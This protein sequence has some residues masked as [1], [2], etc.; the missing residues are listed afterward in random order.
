MHTTARLFMPGA[1]GLVLGA[2]ASGSCTQFP[3]EDA[4]LNVSFDSTRELYQEFNG[5][6][7]A[8]WRVRT[9]QTVTVYQS[10]GGSAKQARAVIEGLAADVVTLALDFDVDQIASKSG[11]LSSGWRSRLPDGAAPY[12]ST[13]VFLVRKG[14]PHGISDWDDLGR[15]GIAVVTPHPKVSGGGRWN[16]LGAWAWALKAYRGDESRA[17]NF[18]AALYRNVPLLEPSSRAAGITFARRGIGDVLVAWESEARFLRQKLGSEFEIVTPSVS[19]RA[20]LPVAVVDRNVERHKT[21]KLAEAYVNFF[22]TPAGQRLLARHH[23]RPRQTEARDA[24][25][26]PFPVLEQVEGE[27]LGGWTAIQKAHFADGGLFDQVYGSP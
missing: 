22:W 2:L 19:V 4:L 24:A 18:M 3:G 13:V 27:A 16:Y 17:R 20:A 7:A 1:I 15:E 21:R 5:A 23:F 25:S 14:N 11:R 6:F 12:T 26:Y 8:D 9:G 10:H